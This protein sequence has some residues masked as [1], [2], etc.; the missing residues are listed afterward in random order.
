MFIF[1][2]AVTARAIRRTW[3]RHL[4]TSA[5]SVEEK[6]QALQKLSQQSAAVP[7]Q[8]VSIACERLFSFNYWGFYSSF[9]GYC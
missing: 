5:L 1:R 9:F 7:W 8:E 6:N 3:I 2:P 4:A